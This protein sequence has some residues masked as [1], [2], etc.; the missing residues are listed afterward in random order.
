[1]VAILHYFAEFDRGKL[2]QIGWN[3]TYTVCDKMQN[4][5]P[6]FQ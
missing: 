1:M 3:Y 4:K 2:R 6:A 5:E